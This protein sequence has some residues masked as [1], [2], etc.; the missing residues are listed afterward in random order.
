MALRKAP[1]G[2]RTTGSSFLS[3]RTVF[4]AANAP[5][6]R[7]NSPQLLFFLSFFLYVSVTCHLMFSVSK[8]L[9][10]KQSK[11][12]KKTNP[13]TIPLCAR[14]TLP[15]WLKANGHNRPYD[16]E[17]LTKHK[18]TCLVHSQTDTLL[19]HKQPCIFIFLWVWMFDTNTGSWKAEIFFCFPEKDGR[20]EIKWAWKLFSLTCQ[21]GPFMLQR[22]TF[23]GLAI[24][25]E[26]TFIRGETVHW[27]L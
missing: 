26:S 7:I 25:E 11:T 21:L 17:N 6:T 1:K 10:T 14:R 5:T 12:K 16:S 4:S 2:T 24:S 27:F 23:Y 22:L 18:E 20:K 9:K 8:G 19:I 3:L 13:K 15:M